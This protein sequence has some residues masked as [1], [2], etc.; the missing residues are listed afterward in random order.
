M[1][2]A[3]YLLKGT[4]RGEEISFAS[5]AH[6]AGRVLSRTG[7]RKR[8]QAKNIFAQLKQKGIV[9]K[10]ASGRIVEEESPDSYKDIH[11]VADVSHN[12]GI[13]RK[14]MMSV[15]VAVAKG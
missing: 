8:F 14:V 5:T 10:A 13:G 2:T 12:L 9:V 15:P 6:G 1:G 11:R 4:E 3:S 7:A